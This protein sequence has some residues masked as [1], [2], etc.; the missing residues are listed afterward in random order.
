MSSA[1]LRAVNGGEATRTARPIDQF[2][3]RESA[4]LVIG[5]SGP[6]GCGL[7]TAVDHTTKALES[8]GYLVTAITLSEYIEKAIAGE[9]VKSSTKDTKGS[10]PAQRYVQLQDGGNALRERF[11]TNDILAEW[12]VT[13]IAEIRTLDIKDRED[14]KA[15]EKHV[16]QKRA[17]LIKQLKHPDEVRLLRSVYR[18]LFF[19][20]G[21]L[22]VETRRQKRLADD[23]MTREEAVQLMERDRR[24]TEEGD[25]KE[26]KA[27][28]Q[29]LEK[30]LELADFFIR[31]DKPNTTSLSQQ[32]SRFVEL[33][34]GANG[35]SPTSEEFGMYIAYASKLASACLS[36]QVGA[37]IVDEKGVVIGTGCNDVPR[38]GGGMYCAEDGVNDARCVKRE[39]RR[40]W[41]DYYNDQLRDDVARE[42]VRRELLDEAKAK[43]V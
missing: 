15:L 1:N 26:I 18:N 16:P 9:F 11:K 4:E 13:R 14:P 32:V 17:F 37:A 10:E 39:G 5:F 42:L 2:S 6:L 41:N 7:R 29:Q 31:N 19:L 20:V 43:E 12:A 38:F 40:C 21:V 28:G 23:G 3:G 22:S 8:A 24:E 25:P 30:T 34:H 33:M 36:R 35:V 27:H